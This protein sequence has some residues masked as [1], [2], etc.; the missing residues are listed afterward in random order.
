MLPASILSAKA[1]WL[2]LTTSVLVSFLA[3]QGSADAGLLT[4]QN[5][6]SNVTYSVYTTTTTA[7]GSNF[8]DNGMLIYPGN[9]LPALNTL[10]S[11]SSQSYSSNG[12]IA[13]GFTTSV[14][15]GPAHFGSAT[16]QDFAGSSTSQGSFT[17]QGGVAWSNKT[18]LTDDL[19]AGSN[20]AS[21]LFSTASATYVNN[22][23]GIV[24]ITPGAVLN[25]AGTLAAYS[26]SG[27]SPYIAAALTTTFTIV[28]DGGTTTINLSPIILASNGTSSVYTSGSGNF[29]YLTSYEGSLTG[30]GTILGNTLS[31]Y[32]GDTIT[33]TSDLTLISDPGST[34][35]V[36]DIIPSND[37]ALPDFG[38]FASADPQIV[39]EPSTIA[40]M[41]CGLAIVGFWTRSNRRRS[42]KA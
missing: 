41:G 17:T 42:P 20:E 14:T 5:S 12:S 24:S 33:I 13:S 40:L 7:S 25:I 26:G 27:P 39:P 38:S 19:P 2:L 6:S 32:S 34:I 9:N 37:P 4:L 30:N 15:E 8:N 11:G 31:L 22:S 23:S 3:V 18:K 1:R 16:N 28:S 29:A 36:S 10:L 21:V 35:G